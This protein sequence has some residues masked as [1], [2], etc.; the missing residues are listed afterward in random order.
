MRRAARTA[1]VQQRE[2][3]RRG[4]SAM[5]PAMPRDAWSWRPA[6]DGGAPSASRVLG[7]LARRSAVAAA[8]AAA[9]RRAVPW[10]AI[11]DAGVP[12]ATVLRPVVLRPAVLGCAVTAAVDAGA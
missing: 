2:R 7:T 6:Y 3:H 1:R 12:R 11:L 8:L 9:R 4:P 10:L 5:P